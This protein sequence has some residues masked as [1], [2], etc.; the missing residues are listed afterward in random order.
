VDTPGRRRSVISAWRT[1]VGAL[2]VHYKSA[3]PTAWEGPFLREER[4]LLDNIAQRVGEY[5]EWKQRELG[6]ERLGAAPEHWR[7]LEIH[8]ADRR[9]HRPGSVRGEEDIPVRE[10]RG[11]LPL[12]TAPATKRD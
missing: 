10:C 7:W 8:G 1:P 3:Q 9:Q 12:G 5:L 11:E 6:G 2:E 4:Q